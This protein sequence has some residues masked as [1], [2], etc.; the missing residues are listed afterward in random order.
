M[1]N[2]LKVA[3]LK[4][5]LKPMLLKVSGNKSDLID[6]LLDSIK[7]GDER[8]LG[9]LNNVWCVIQCH[10]INTTKARPF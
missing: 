1:L 7:F 2:K 4:Q 3:E 5:L 10:N 6:R 8:I 9:P